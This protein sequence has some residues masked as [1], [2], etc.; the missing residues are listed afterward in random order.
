MNFWYKLEMQSQP[1]AA[2]E[3]DF[4]SRCKLIQRLYWIKMK[5]TFMIKNSYH[6]L[7]HKA[8]NKNAWENVKS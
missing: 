6:N 1:V 2:W 4:P 7:Q 5:D 3:M 8:R